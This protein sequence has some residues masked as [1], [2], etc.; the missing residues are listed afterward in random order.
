M[1][2]EDRSRNAHG[3]ARWATVLNRDEKT[4]RGF[5]LLEL[6]LVMAILV[7]FSALALPSVRKS[8][9]RQNVIK[10]ADLLRASMGRARVRAIKTG[11]VYAV[12][13]LPNSSYHSVAPFDN[14]TSQAA[15]A[16]QRM[17]QLENRTALEDFAEDLLPRGVRFAAANAIV[18]GRAAEVLSVGESNSQLRPLLFYPDG[19]S[20]DAKIVLQNESGL[21]VQVVLRGLTGTSTATRITTQ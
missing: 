9:D 17:L 8:L 4:R 21:M 11:K 20:Q 7:A 3:T 16:S 10:G 19:T 13:Y 6:I 15:L 14:A 2:V 18:D 5:S 1:D 12:F